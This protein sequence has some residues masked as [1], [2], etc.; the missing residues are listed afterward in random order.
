MLLVAFGVPSFWLRTLYLKLLVTLVSHI[1]N[2]LD[3]KF[4]VLTMTMTMKIL[5][6]WDFRDILVTSY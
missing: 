5:N 2:S 1:I 4:C 3:F 6:I